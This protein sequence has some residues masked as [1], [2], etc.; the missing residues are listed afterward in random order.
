MKIII[1]SFLFIFSLSAWSFPKLGDFVRFEAEFQGD[2]YRLEKKVIDHNSSTDQFTVRTLVLV[3]NEIVQDQTHELPRSFLYT[4]EKVDNVFKTCVAREGALGDI[5][6]EGRPLRVCEFY[7]ED[8][9]MTYMIGKVPFGQVRFQ[10]YLKDEDFL[11]FN[12]KRFVHG[13]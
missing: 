13:E 12:L 3:N 4:P 10:I 2:L 5:K 9:Q 6:I 8:S 7:N 11:D 1:C